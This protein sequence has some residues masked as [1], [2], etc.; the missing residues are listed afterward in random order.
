VA[1]VAKGLLNAGAI[2]LVPGAASFIAPG[3][4]VNP[5]FWGA[6]TSLAAGAV[7]SGVSAQLLGKPK[8][9]RAQTDVEY[10]GTVEPRR[11]I[12]GELLVAGMH[13]IPPL[14]SGDNN[15]YLHSVLALAGHEVSDITDVY[16]WQDLIED[17]DI[18]AVTGA[19]GDGLV[20][21]GPYEDRAWIRRY[22]GTA[23][24]TA[25]Y[26]LDTA[27]TQW[28]SSHRGRGVAYAAIQLQLDEGVYKNG[29]PEVL[30]RVFGKKCY[31]PRL[32][33]SPGANPSNPSYIVYTNNPALC[34]ADYLTDD[35]VGMGEGHELIDWDMV[36]EAA[37]ICD[38]LVAVPTSATQR[39]YTCNIA[40]FATTAYERNIEALAACMLGSCLNSGGLWRI[41]AGAWEVPSFEIT[42]DSVMGRMVVST[43]YPYKERWN[44]I[45]GSYVDQENLYQPDEFPAVQDA[46]YVTEDG[47]PVFKDTTFAGCTNVFEA[48]RNGIMLVRK[49][50]NRISYVG[51]HDLGL[52]KVRPGMTGIVTIPELNWTNKTVR[53]ESWG[54]NPLGTVELGLREE[55]ASDWNDP[56]EADY[57]APLS[58]TPPPPA[59]FTP[60]A[61]SGLA[62]VSTPR[63]PQMSWT[64]P[65]LLP[66]GAY[67]ELYEHTSS[68]P[69]SSAV[70]IWEGDAT[71]AVIPRNDQTTRYYW[72]RVVTADGIAGP[73]HP[74]GAAGVSGVGALTAVYYTATGGS[75]SWSGTP[76]STHTFVSVTVPDQGY[77]SEVVVT[78]TANLGLTATVLGA[79]GV[80]AY[81]HTTT[82]PFYDATLAN[83]VVLAYAAS[84]TA[85]NNVSIT[86]RYTQASGASV[87]YYALGFDA[88]SDGS[89]K[90]SVSI[91]ASVRRI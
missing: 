43:A 13:V 46:T 25:D 73:E 68:V 39:R 27:F 45:R 90:A 36:A 67:Y 12:Y 32:D 63:G 69:F 2:L 54:F 41:R 38:E 82:L 34:L 76:S 42:Q 22:L 26:I 49:S 50:R 75:G 71:N 20:T 79:G 57:T 65:A 59:Y 28:T 37:D 88:N 21:G 83:A 40:L 44:G 16:F 84:S 6:A 66:T 61:P 55:S 47:E 10:A 9:A 53:C 52:W 8:S 5:T 56:V 77:D 89:S 58:I 4:F 70:K 1:K 23:T 18:A 19:A 78:F 74:T 17:A 7:L 64:A 33:S 14:T 29:R 80:W 3:L 48:Q 30:F 24:Q 35:A 81:V 72:I 51:Q 31:D 62:S 11:I 15:R 85:G 87:T 60:S 86:E 91:I